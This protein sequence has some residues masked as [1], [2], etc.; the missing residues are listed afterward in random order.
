MV[1]NFSKS[2]KLRKR[3]GVRP[4]KIFKNAM[5]EKTVRKKG[6]GSGF[7]ETLDDIDPGPGPGSKLPSPESHLPESPVIFFKLQ[8]AYIGRSGL[9]KA[10]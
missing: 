3:E 1:V 8:T 10:W 4:R 5:V 2:F 9:I 7:L 6:G